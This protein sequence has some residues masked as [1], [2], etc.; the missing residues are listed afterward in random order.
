PIDD[1]NSIDALVRARDVRDDKRSPV[2]AG[3]VDAVESPLVSK[4]AGTTG[5]HCEG[6]S[7]CRRKIRAERLRRNH[8]KLSRR[9]NRQWQVRQP[10]VIDGRNFVSAKSALPNAKVINVGRSGVV[11]VAA[12]AD[13]GTKSRIQGGAAGWVDIADVCRGAVDIACDLVCSTVEGDG[14]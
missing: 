14:H 1:E 5:Y 10:R 3:N 9:G 13:E 6:R 4:R 11:A 12:A 2:G 7:R 8:G